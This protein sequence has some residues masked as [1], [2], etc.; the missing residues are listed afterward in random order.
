[1][2][3]DT[4][5]YRP[6]SI[7][8]IFAKMFEKLIYNRLIA[9]LESK[10]ILQN[11]QFGLRDGKNTYQAIYNLISEITVSLQ[12][13]QPT[14]AVF[15]D[16]SKAFDSVDHKILLLKMDHYGIRGIINNW[17]ASFLSDRCQCVKVLGEGS[18]YFSHPIPI[19]KGVPQGSI[20]GPL[21]FILYVNDL[22]NITTHKITQ[23]ADDTSLV[24]CA[25]TVSQLLN[26]VVS[27]L[28]LL[29]N[30]FFHNNL[31]LNISKTNIML[32]ALSNSQKDSLETLLK[33]YKIDPQQ[34]TAA[35]KF[36]GI[37]IQNNLKWEP[38]H[39]YL[40]NKLSSINY[41]LLHLRR[42]I[43]METL[44]LAY[45]GLFQSLASY[46]IH[47]WGGEICVLQSLF[48]QQKRAVRT[49][50]GLSC[51]ESCKPFF[52]NEKIQTLTSLYILHIAYFAHMFLKP[53]TPQHNYNTRNLNA[54][55]PHTFRTQILQKNAEF[56]SAKV[57]NSLPNDL[58]NID[59]PII[60]KKRLGRWLEKYGFYSVQEYLDSSSN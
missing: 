44:K 43:N 16:L 22:P 34:I 40:S 47:F 17:F 4:N 15:C 46:G 35:S 8:P 33:Y 24:L 39:N 21:L 60:F 6:I 20:L 13:K 49:I 31:K 56:M 45:F 57:Y 38:H 54:I 3:N 48:K 12:N 5:N 26:E 19:L 2:A 41:L 7:V 25:P 59:S 9:F 51:T 42:V 23:Y 53:I 36:L 14:A 58:K 11:Y 18:T 27:S 32:F 55:I 30:W 50:F 52:V 1:M 28:N 10:S 29:N 37:H